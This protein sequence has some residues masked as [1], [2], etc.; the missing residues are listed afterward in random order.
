MVT[1]HSSQ[2]NHRKTNT[3]PCGKLASDSHKLGFYNELQSRLQS[4]DFPSCVTD[5]A[6]SKNEVHSGVTG[7]K[8]GQVRFHDFRAQMY[9]KYKALEQLILILD[10]EIFSQSF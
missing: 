7:V 5:C 4:L 1:K 8:R 9:T 6:N 10:F 3:H 2:S